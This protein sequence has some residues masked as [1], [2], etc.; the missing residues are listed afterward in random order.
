MMLALQMHADAMLAASQS[1]KRH[2]RQQELD[3]EVVQTAI[4]R[5]EELCPKKSLKLLAGRP[6]MEY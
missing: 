1:K 5:V 4:L 6:T 2:R 3:D